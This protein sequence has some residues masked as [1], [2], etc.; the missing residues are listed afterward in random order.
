MAKPKP[1]FTIGFPDFI[2][3]E[4][5]IETMKKLPA[6]LRKEYHLIC[7]PSASETEPIFNCF[8]E[9]DFNHI[10]YIELKKFIEDSIKK[11]K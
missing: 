8:Y 2:S 10:K 4:E 3:D 5:R 9:K 6:E 1:I 11:Q 7:Y